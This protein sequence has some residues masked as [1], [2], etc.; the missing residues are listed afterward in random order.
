MFSWRSV[1]ALLAALVLVACGPTPG[2]DD[3]DDS[4]DAAPECYPQ[5]R[6]C[7]LNDLYECHSG[8]YEL[9]GTCE[10]ACM[11][12]LGCVECVPGSGSCASGLASQCKADGSGYVTFECDPVQGME[13]D[14]D[15][16]RCQGPCTPLNLGTNYIGCEYYPTVTGNEVDGNFEFAV[17][18]SNTTNEA[19]TVTIDWGALASPLT[20][21]VQPNMV[22]VQKL[23]W[24]VD[25]KACMSNGQLECGATTAQAALV[26]KGAYRLRST[27]PVTVYQFNPLD[28]MIN[29]GAQYAY[30]NDASLLLPSNALTANYTVAAWPNWYFADGGLTMPGLIAVTATQD[31]TDVGLAPNAATQAGGG[32]PA[33]PAYTMTHVSL[34]KGDVL[35][36]FAYGGDLTGSVVAATKPVQVIGGHYCTQSP[37]GYTA[38]D[39]LEESMIPYEALSTRYIVTAPAVPAQPNGRAMIVRIIAT[40]PDTTITYDPPVAGAPTSLASGG[41]F[42][43]IVQPPGGGYDFQVTANHKV[44][45]ASYMVGQDYD[46]SATGDPAFAQAV[47]VDQY[48]LDYLFHAP[49]NYETNYVNVIAQT[50]A[51][52]TLDGVQVS[53]YVPIGGSG[54]GVA[55]VQLSNAGDGNHIATGDQPFGISVYGYGQYTSF[56]YPGGLDLVPIPVE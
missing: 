45:V 49:T 35:E 31:G 22:Q 28:Y 30:T 32:A 53:G 41:Q 52:V 2:D 15:S 17:A 1:L 37:I 33:F 50:G 39:H 23:P 9:I 36:V 11:P 24:V 44:M 12:E 3:D 43:E 8:R 27:R 56:W 34:D 16:G 5:Q 19:A 38:C 54:H 46:G 4:F 21:T 20:F 26:R 42:I 14:L 10:K 51:T 13:C 40:Q 6:M 48:R 29:G 47:P 55:R 18:V 25:L 7:Q